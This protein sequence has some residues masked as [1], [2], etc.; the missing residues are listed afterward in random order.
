MKP[1]DAG[2]GKSSEALHHRAPGAPL[3][4][5][6][7]PNPFSGECLAQKW[8]RSLG[9][10]AGLFLIGVALGSGLLSSLRAGD[11]APS[12]ARVKAAFLLNFPK[13]IEWPTNAFAETNS[14]IVVAV[15]GA[16]SI[17]DEFAAMSEGRNIE[18]RPVRLV[19]VTAPGPSRD[20]HILFIGG[21]QNRKLADTLSKLRGLNIL[22]VGE[23]D[24]FLEAGGMINLA[25]HDRRIVLEVNV[26]SIHAAGLKVSSKLLA[27]ATLKGGKK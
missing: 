26:D 24:G 6:D 1:S 13:Y 5:S 14:P 11:A 7:R 9:R 21:G 25:R 8:L 17:A 3:P 2:W 18:G 22:L 10:W 23:S 20:C 27:V 19:R 12:E 15:L 16:D 4:V